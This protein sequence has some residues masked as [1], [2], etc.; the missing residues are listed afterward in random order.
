MR[1]QVLEEAQRQAEEIWSTWPENPMPVGVTAFEW[2]EQEAFDDHWLLWWPVVTEREF[3]R[4]GPWKNCFINVARCNATIRTGVRAGQLCQTPAG[5]GTDH[6][7]AGACKWHKGNRQAERA[8]A[9]WI[10]A[11]AF[12]REFMITPWDALLM[13][14]RIAAG[15]LM[16]AQQKI[17][18]AQDD[19]ELE[20]RLVR[21]T[22]E[23]GTLAMYHPD[24]GEVLGL[25][26]FKDLSFW[27]DQADK[28]HERMLKSAKMA[29]DAG[30]AERLVES[31]MLQVQL[32][33]R[34]VEAALRAL[35]LS[36][37]QE[38]IARAAMRQELIA[39]E[40]AGQATLDGVVIPN[41]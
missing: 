40:S 20:G 12:A 4:V 5:A 24:T 2:D 7:G 1:D 31:Q 9:A 30:V 13:A 41:N 28:W 32:M 35:N 15:K 18:E 25:G 21:R 29:V 17:A 38:S 10:M 16:Y 37:E 36:P 39:I 33:A 6:F 3:E 23:D 8:K 27:V 11:H 34:P 22:L 14:V 26:A 19:L